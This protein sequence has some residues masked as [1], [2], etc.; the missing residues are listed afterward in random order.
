MLTAYD[1]SSTPEERDQLIEW[2]GRPTKDPELARV[3]IIYSSVYGE[4]WIVR[5]IGAIPE[6]LPTEVAE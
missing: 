2:F 6:S 5:G 3:E 1:Y 4:R